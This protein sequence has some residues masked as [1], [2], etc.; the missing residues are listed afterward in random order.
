MS[1]PAVSGTVDILVVGAG[2]VGLLSSFL[3]TNLGLKVLAI[4]KS[5][6]PLKLGR[7]DAMNARTLQLLQTL[8]SGIFDELYPQGLICNT[9]ST[10]KDGQFAS[11]QSKWWEALAGCEHR[12]FLMLGQ[13][14]VEDILDRRLQELENPVQ[15]HTTVTRIWTSSDDTAVFA[16]LLHNDGEEEIIQAKYLIG[17][18]GSHSFVRK[19]LDI[20]FEGEGI[21]MTWAVIDC[22][23]ETTFPNVPEIIN[24]QVETSDV[25]RIPREG[26]I[27]RYYV[28]MDSR[29]FTTED[30][31]AK[32]ERALQPH[33]IKFTRI[34]WASQF[35]VQERIA[36]QFVW[37]NR[38]F[39]AGDAGHVH[40]VNGGQGLNTGLM[41]AFNL[42]WK[43]YLHAQGLAN[44]MILQSY[45]QERRPVAQTV[46]ETAGKLVRATKYA[47]G[48]APGTFFADSSTECRD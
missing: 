43:I 30:A 12:H 48:L 1:S 19:A 45:E 8:Q 24:F 6:G 38:V 27:N 36:K 37:K 18:D 44:D 25:A 17:A 15:R 22:E 40:S 42:S 35:T 2:P 16:T 31:I 10:F 13:P 11:R 28:H 3:T 46:I 7:A 4:D 9:S 26:K 47:R 32:I 33:P 23:T 39:L 14:Y 21:D 29:D 20:A 5:D 34:E 41:D